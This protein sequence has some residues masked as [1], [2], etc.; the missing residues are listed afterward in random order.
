MP[1]GAVA[2]SELREARNFSTFSGTTDRVQEQ[3]GATS[4]GGCN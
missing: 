4:L 1:S 3:L 2:E